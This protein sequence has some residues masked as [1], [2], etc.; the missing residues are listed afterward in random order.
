MSFLKVSMASA[1]TLL[2]LAPS[3]LAGYDPLGA[4]NVAIYWG[5][6]SAA[7]EDSQERLATYCSGKLP[8]RPIANLPIY[9]YLRIVSR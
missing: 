6:N 8:P 1:A 5:Q 4:N 9:A 2:S 3:V 7:R